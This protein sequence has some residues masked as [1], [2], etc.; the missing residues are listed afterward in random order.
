MRIEKEAMTGFAGRLRA[1]MEKRGMNQTQLAQESG[2]T[3]AAI[4]RII[5]ADRMP[6]AASLIKIT[7]ALDVSA[8]YL[9]GRHEDAEISRTKGLIKDMTAMVDTYWTLTAMMEAMRERLKD[10]D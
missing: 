10:E 3:V 2:L 9:I 8:D 4:S 6:N 5:N 7:N 1:A